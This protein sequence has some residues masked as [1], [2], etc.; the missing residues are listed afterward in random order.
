MARSLALKWKKGAVQRLNNDEEKP[1]NDAAKKQ[2]ESKKSSNAKKSD[3]T[4]TVDLP[5][6]SEPAIRGL[7]MVFSM[8]DQREDENK[9]IKVLTKKNNRLMEDFITENEVDEDVS[10]DQ[11]LPSMLNLLIEYIKLFLFLYNC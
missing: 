5:N 6:K 11:P 10:D 9:T 7:K 4:K 1:K 2:L 3:N 8:S